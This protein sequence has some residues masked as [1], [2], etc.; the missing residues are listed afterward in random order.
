MERPETVP[1]ASGTVQPRTGSGAVAR[2]GHPAI[3]RLSACARGALRALGERERPRHP[4]IYQ[5]FGSG[6]HVCIGAQL[7]TM[8][9]K[10]YW[11]DFLRR[12]RFRLKEDY[13]AR[14]TASPLGTVSGK[15]ELILE[16]L[17]H[18]TR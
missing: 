10:A 11:H 17:T 14:H 18:A 9:V 3:G 2:F 15:V 7:A 5:P 16:P 8:E 13:D 12:C 1:P 6:P 4:R